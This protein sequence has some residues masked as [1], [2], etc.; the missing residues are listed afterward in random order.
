MIAGATVADSIGATAK[1]AQKKL[2]NEVINSAS[3]PRLH[4]HQPDSVGTADISRQ[5]DHT[6]ETFS[7]MHYADAKR[8]YLLH[9]REQIANGHM[10]DTT[11]TTYQSW[12]NRYERWLDTNNYPTPSIGDALVT[13]PIRRWLTELRVVHGNSNT[14]ISAAWG[15]INELCKFL[16]SDKVMRRNPMDHV[17]RPRKSKPTQKVAHE[18]DIE[19]LLQAAERQIKPRD[20]TMS[21][22]LVATMLY[23]G[24]RAFEIVQM[25]ISDVDLR[26]HTL[27]VPNGKG[28]TSEIMYPAPEFFDSIR[29][30]LSERDKIGCQHDSLWAQDRRRGISDDW[31]RSHI[32]DLQIRAGIDPESPLTPHAIRRSFA[33][34]LDRNGASLLTIQKALRH[35]DP[36]TTHI[37]LRADDKDARALAS[38]GGFDRKSIAGGI[39]AVTPQQESESRDASRQNGLFPPRPRASQSPQVN[40]L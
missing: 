31:L 1:K 38:Y 15:A 33:R 20:A 17:D 21:M 2:P 36:R 23:T 30:W 39:A 13:S 16:V 25:R 18:D 3:P 9:I 4:A 14:T 29:A 12:L 10:R 19:K 40:W 34:R 35:A 27:Q 24:L 6:S 32:H 28:G 8:A 11:H 26:A 22:A 5:E 37:Y 7:T